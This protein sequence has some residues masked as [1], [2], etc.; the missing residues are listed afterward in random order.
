MEFTIKLLDSD[1]VITKKIN[2]AF[3]QHIKSQ[4]P[5][6]YRKCAS[7]MQKTVVEGIKAEGTYGALLSGDLRNQFGL[8]NADS[9]VDQ[10]LKIV[11][12]SIVIE[13]KAPRIVSSKI[14]GG[15]TISMVPADYSD[16][17]SS[18]AAV[19]S[20]GKNQKLDWLKWLLLYGDRTIISGYEFTIENDKKSRTGRGIM[21]GSVS[22]AWRVPSDYA[23]NV[24]NNWIIKGISSVA[25]DIEN[26][27]FRTLKNM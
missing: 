20:T 9:K 22:G 12:D 7:F 6:A 23:G 10:I 14:V 27:F 15:F 24:D 16:I 2:Q 11:E 17:L 4:L 19:Q 1:V 8:T 21:Q 18:G 5:K 13:Y 25:D 3:L 26:F